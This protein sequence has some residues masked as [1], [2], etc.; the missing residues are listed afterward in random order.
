MALGTQG[1]L[2]PLWIRLISTHMN[3]VYILIIVLIYVYTILYT[4]VHRYGISRC[5]SNRGL[6]VDGL[7][8]GCGSDC[9]FLS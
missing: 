5:F 6:G 9:L 1:I 4:F 3:N 8:G 2:S 7:S